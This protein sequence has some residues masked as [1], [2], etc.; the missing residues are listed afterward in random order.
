MYGFGGT[1]GANPQAEA[2]AVLPNGKLLVAGP[3]KTGGRVVV[4]N[5]VLVNK[6]GDIGVVRLN[7][8]GT[9]DKTFANRGEATVSFNTG[10][11]NEDGVTVLSVDSSGRIVIAGTGTRSNGTQEIVVMRLTKNGGYDKTFGVGGRSY[12]NFDPFGF[13]G[14]NARSMVID[15]QGRIVVAGTL[16]Q[17]NGQ[18]E[19]GVIRLN[20]N[21]YLDQSFGNQGRS[22]QLVAIPDINQDIVSGVALDVQGRIVVTGSVLGDGLEV[23]GAMRLQSNGSLDSTFGYQGQTILPTDGNY[24]F[25]T[26]V[27]INPQ[28]QIILAGTSIQ[29]EP[30][31]SSEIL[32]ARLTP[33]GQF[34]QSY[35]ISGFSHADFPLGGAEL[36]QANALAIDAAGRIVIAGSISDGTH[37]HSAVVRL[38]PNGFYDTAF[39]VGGRSDA[40][41]GLGYTPGDGAN[42]LTFD[43]SGRII[44]AGYVTSPK[45][46]EFGVA[47]ISVS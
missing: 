9:V 46:Y 22:Y 13:T 43:H 14:V 7:A 23:F 31:Y 6:V 5:R 19:F 17:P 37:V 3:I 26:A 24:D 8:N 35:G 34:D 12:A 25:G 28:G 1:T 29:T 33:S 10:V 36:A 47:R 45:G 32:T 38:Q 41:F 20:A 15:P 16:F 30:K 42:A 18:N 40:G 27:A 2:V 21:G 4:G 44:I 11:N 39:G